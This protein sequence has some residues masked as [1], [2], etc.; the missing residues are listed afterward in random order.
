[1]FSGFCVDRR[2]DKGEDMRRIVI[3]LVGVI[4]V[5]GLAAQQSDP[6]PTCKMCPGTYIPRSE[7]EAYTAKAVA[8]NLIDQQARDIDI[9]KAHIGIGM[10][11]QELAFCDNLTV[12]ENLFINRQPLQNGLPNKIIDPN[13]GQCCTGNSRTSP[14]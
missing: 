10:V 13:N 14:S 3:G 7:I 5:V 4:G 9:G 8:E 6:Q 2:D 11:H 12:A 1:V